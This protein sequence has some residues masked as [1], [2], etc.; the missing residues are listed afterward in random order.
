MK[1]ILILW[2]ITGL[3]AGGV[4]YAAE[5]QFDPRLVPP[6]EI[7]STPA[8]DPSN[9]NQSA[10]SDQISVPNDGPVYEEGASG[11]I[12]RGAANPVEDFSEPDPSELTM[13]NAD[14]ELVENSEHGPIPITMNGRQPW[15]Y[16]ARP[17]NTNNQTPRVAIV[18]RDMGLKANQTEMAIQRLPGAVTF[19]FSAQASDLDKWMN[20]AKQDTHESL[21]MIPMEPVNYP[22][23]NPGPR[24]LVTN[25]EFQRNI[26]NLHYF[27][28]RTNGYVGVMND[29]GGRFTA[30][31]NAMKDLM[32][33]LQ[34][35]GLMFLDARTSEFSVAATAARN[36]GLPR[37]INDR[38]I[39]QRLT[40][41]DIDRA[42][43]ELEGIAN[44]YGAAV[45]VGRPY[46]ITIGRLNQWI[47]SL[48]SKGI[49]LVP[50]TAVANRQP[51]R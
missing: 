39:D 46:P 7:P 29:M 20:D 49:K 36:A 45:G 22:Q 16:Y 27:L 47:Q 41:Q 43:N 44:T 9:P 12:N 23:E 11:A 51:I 10:L 32:I 1:V 3:L 40:A 26:S 4:Y 6:S 5:Q 38:N 31:R 18:I 50:I 19:A 14:P 17:D 42:L 24:T 35:R 2:F 28:S 33:D 34:R 25:F 21:M 30:N 48:P 13:N 37:A 8:M 15:Q